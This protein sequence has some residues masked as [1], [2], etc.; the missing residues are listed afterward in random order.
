MA[1]RPANK[2]R[3]WAEDPLALDIIPAPASLLHVTVER[4]YRT[5]KA[6]LSAVLERHGSTIVEW[7]ILLTLHHQGE[8][9]QKD[10]VR[11]V[12]MVQAQVSR[13]LAGMKRRGLV[14]AVR[15]TQD[16]RIW[17]YTATPK[18]AALY[19]RIAPAMAMRKRRLDHCL[20]ERE[21]QAFL[22]SSRKI[23][24]V[25]AGPGNDIRRLDEPG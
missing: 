21:L 19:R 15:S 25:A 18:G 3:D 13:S 7:R 6:Q 5:L 2:H 11:E 1:E 8:T 17:L 16:R 23:A 24:G 9:A 20:S 10:L 22:A 14:R 12:A 4:L